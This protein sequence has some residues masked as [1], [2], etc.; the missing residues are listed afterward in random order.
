MN[1]LQMLR[2][3]LTLLCRNSAQVTCRPYL[4]DGAS[5]IGSDP[6][7][8]ILS[9][10]KLWLSWATTSFQLSVGVKFVDFNLVGKF[11]HINIG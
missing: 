1:F 3:S 10:N 5:I 6:D 2:R 9:P 4:T 8:W 7:R 11:N